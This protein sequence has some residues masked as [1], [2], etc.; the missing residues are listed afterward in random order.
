[1]IV[2]A[3]FVVLEIFPGLDLVTVVSLNNSV[4]SEVELEVMILAIIFFAEDIMG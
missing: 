3:G 2:W 4:G 1:L